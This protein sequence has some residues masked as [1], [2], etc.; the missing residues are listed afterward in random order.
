MLSLV[1]S[2]FITSRLSPDTSRFDQPLFVVVE[3]QRL[4]QRQFLERCRE[5]IRL[6]PLGGGILAL[7][8]PR[9][10]RKDRRRVH[11]FMD[12]QGHGIHLKRRAF[13]L[14]R[15]GQVGGLHPLE[16]QQ[17]ILHRLRFAAGQ[18]VVDQL[19]HPGSCGVEV[20]H[21][22][23]MRVIGPNGFR[24]VRIGARMHHPHLGVVHP[25][26]AMPIGHH[27]HRLTRFARGCPR[28]CRFGLARPGCRLFRRGQFET[29]LGIVSIILDIAGDAKDGPATPLAA[30]E[31]TFIHQHIAGGRIV[32]VR[33]GGDL[34]T[35]KRHHRSVAD[36][37][38]I[39]RG[40]G[41]DQV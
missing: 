3:I 31:Q 4:A 16:F 15:P 34:F 12:M 6:P 39:V 13:R 19:F 28:P 27:L 14:A 36:G 10:R 30:P 35:Q 25:R 5:Q 33:Q 24:P 9:G 17:G 8:P 1:S 38:T 18:C 2:E 23:Q 41:Q 7:Q 21:R 29:I 40:Q 22:V 37:R 26:L 20:Q 32:I 11:P